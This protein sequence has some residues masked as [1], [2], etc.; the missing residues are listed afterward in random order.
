MPSRY[1]SLVA[2]FKATLARERVSP[3]DLD[4]LADGY[5]PGVDRYHNPLPEIE[6]DPSTPAPTTPLERLEAALAACGSSVSFD[7]RD[8][9]EGRPWDRDKVYPWREYGWPGNKSRAATKGTRRWSRVDTICLHTAGTKGMG[10]KRW[11]GVPCH[12][13]VADDATVVLCHRSLALLWA[14]HDL[15]RRSISMEI[16]GDRDI[17]EALIE[18]SRALLRYNVED[19][20]AHREPG[21]PIYLS[22]HT[23]GH[24]SRMEDCGKWIWREVGEWGL[25]T[26]GLQVGKPIGRGRPF[27]DEWWSPG[28][29]F[30]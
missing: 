13:A 7:F 22:P 27:S 10:P 25:D 9:G 29:S 11:L 28:R 30:G 4:G 14:A 3:E 21:A 15:N 16:A 5:I 26:L 18:P 1:T 8:A 17:A 20:R 12:N 6:R 23:H 2:R 24:Y 19:A